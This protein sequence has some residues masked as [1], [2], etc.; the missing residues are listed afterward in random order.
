MSQREKEE[1]LRLLREQLQTEKRLV[2]MY[3]E[4]SDLIMSETAGWL[5]QMLQMD[6]RKHIAIF[7]LAIEILEGRRFGEADRREVSVGLERHLELERESVE[8]T[9]KILG[10]RLVRENSGLSR[11][12]EIWSDDERMHHRTLLRLRD[13][14]YVRMDAFDAYAAH[15]R[16]AFEQLANEIKRLASRQ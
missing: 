3:E 2:E 5:L 16:A 9:R 7:N 8:R 12:L 10:N 15:R 1:A 13:E 4:T 14:R 6:S 11:L